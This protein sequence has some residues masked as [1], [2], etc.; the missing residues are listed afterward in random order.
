[1]ISR[2]AKATGRG[3]SKHQAAQEHRAAEAAKWGEQAAHER[4]VTKTAKRGERSEAA[5]AGK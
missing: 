5:E 1:V 4:R 2:A 3:K